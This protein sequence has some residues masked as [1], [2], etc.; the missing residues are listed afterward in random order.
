MVACWV[1]R[2]LL[3]ARLSQYYSWYDT[4]VKGLNP[5]PAACCA[6]SG[7]APKAA[8][9]P[10]PARAA[11]AR[12]TPASAPRWAWPRGQRRHGRRS[13]SARSPGRP[14]IAAP[15]IGEEIDLNRP[16]PDAGHGGERGADFGIAHGGKA[17][18]R[19]GTARDRLGERLEASA[20]ARD[21][22]SRSQVASRLRLTV[23]GLEAGR[24][25]PRSAA[26][27]RP[28]PGAR[29]SGR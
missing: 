21:R 2:R 19:H 29:S 8:A 5:R 18:E 20:L 16:A 22:P 24:P 4:A 13:G 12:T 23:L 9:P 25:P 17:L 1:L 28:P 15:Q 27:S 6:R 3:R 11:R 7:N 26:R 14:D 10:P